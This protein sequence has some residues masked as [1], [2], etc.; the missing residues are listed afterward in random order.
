MLTFDGVPVTDMG[1]MTLAVREPDA[2]LI[3][4]AALMLT[5]GSI[6]TVRSGQMAG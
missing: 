1:D 3:A 6:V 5:S 2:G 4:I